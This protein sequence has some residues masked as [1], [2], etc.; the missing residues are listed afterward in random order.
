M[1]GKVGWINSKS[2]T[3]GS[4]WCEWLYWFSHKTSLLTNRSEIP[5]HIAHVFMFILSM[6][7]SFSYCLLLFIRIHATLPNQP[8]HTHHCHIHIH[9]LSFTVEI[10][11]YIYTLYLDRCVY[12]GDEEKKTEVETRITMWNDIF[13]FTFP[14]WFFKYFILILPLLLIHILF[15]LMNSIRR[16]FIE[17]FYQVEVE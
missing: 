2:C 3:Q 1:G 10:I 8:P 14:A 15:Y 5:P 11:L 12:D 16:M 9:S 13:C 17:D 7:M 4:I 6:W